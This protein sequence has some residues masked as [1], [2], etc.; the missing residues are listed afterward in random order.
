MSIFNITIFDFFN[1][2]N[3]VCWNCPIDFKRKPTINTNLVSLIKVEHRCLSPG[4][5]ELP[6]ILPSPASA[7]DGTRTSISSV[8]K[9][10]L[11]FNGKATLYVMLCY[12]G[13]LRH[14]SSIIQGARTTHFALFL[15]PTPFIDPTNTT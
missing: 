7:V 13:V 9:I 10:F 6:H 11:F 3:L 14:L 2:L 15:R 8:L 5:G 1:L 12:Y 4:E